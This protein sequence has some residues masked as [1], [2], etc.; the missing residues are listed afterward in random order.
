[1]QTEVIAEGGRRSNRDDRAA[2]LGELLQLWHRL[3]DR[4]PAKPAA[5]FRGDAV[6]RR[7]SA[8]S[9]A[10]RSVAHGNGAVDEHQHVVLRIQIA[11]IERR[12][13]H[14]FERELVLLEQPARPAG[15]HR[16]AVLIPQA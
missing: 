4:Y 12:G 11:G 15:W 8:E 14:D 2:V 10:S 5:E 6:G 7:L 9:A 13:I 3:R 16:S 1:R